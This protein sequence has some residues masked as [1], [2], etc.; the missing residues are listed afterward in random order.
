MAGQKETPRQK[1]IGMMYLVLTA[2]L[3]LNVSKDI[4][5]A[6][7]VVN[8]GLEVNLE[9]FGEKN[10]RL[11]A[12]LDLAKAVDTKKATPFWEDAQRIKDAGHELDLFLRELK[13][14]VIAQTEDIPM[15]QARKTPLEDTDNKDNYDI[16]T[17]IMM[18]SSEDG[19]DGRS[20][21]LRKKI[22]AFRILV[23]DVLSKHRLSTDDLGLEIT[24]GHGLENNESWEQHNFY[25]TPL[26]GMITILSKLQNDVRNVEYQSV[27]GLLDALDA[28]RIPFDTVAARVMPV[29][30]YVLLG[31]EYQADVFLAAFSKTQ[32][33]KML[34]GDVDPETNEI[35]SVTD[36]LEVNNGMGALR[37]QTDREGVFNYNGVI[38]YTLENGDVKTFPFESEYIVARPSLV[39]SPV[40]MNVLY[41]GVDND[42]EISV[43]G[44]A[45]ENI[46]AR[47]TGGNRL[48]KVRNGVY[49]TAMA[50][51]SPANVEVQVSAK[52]PDG[53]TR[54]MGSMKFRVKP[55]PKP[56]ATF[57]R[58]SSGKISMKEIKAG[59]FLRCI[60]EEGFPYALSAK[61]TKFE[62]FTRV[63]N[64]PVF[65][66]P[67]VGP[68]LTPDM[69]TTLEKLRRGDRFSFEGIEA[70][71]QAGGKHELGSIV[72]EVI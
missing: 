68:E 72:F 14:E 5:E 33:P 2:L 46:E 32:S 6:F 53:S 61:V 13:V 26:A 38:N 10:H 9:N 44:V 69:K 62:L 35:S 59:K 45:S 19:S 36:S 50:K 40:K 60:Y 7:V 64:K 27:I 17:H 47:I 65:L 71:D 1:M 49:K 23:A 39:V 25:H 48:I 37:I 16:P 12:E 58:K 66:D 31:E 11:Y 20:S 54:A 41:K 55:L 3:A 8:Q 30:N 63:R 52:M 28:G 43:P 67:A 42:L 21:E 29:S 22:E 24:D 4:L 18:G 34:L 70:K 15:D 57:M 51:G 56:Y